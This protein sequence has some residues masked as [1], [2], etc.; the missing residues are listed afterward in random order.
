MSDY[1]SDGSLSEEGGEEVYSFS[2]DED[3]SDQLDSLSNVTSASSSSS[4]LQGSES[5]GLSDSD[6]QRNTFSEDEENSR[7]AASV[8]EIEN[9]FLQRRNQYQSFYQEGGINLTGVF[10]LNLEH[11]YETRKNERV[12]VK[13][14]RRHRYE[15]GNLVDALMNEIRRR[16]IYSFPQTLLLIHVQLM[17]RAFWLGNNSERDLKKLKT[18]MFGFYPFRVNRYQSALVFDTEIMK[19]EVE[20]LDTLLRLIERNQGAATHLFVPSVTAYLINN[21]VLNTDTLLG[22]PQQPAYSMTIDEANARREVAQIR[23]SKD[24]YGS[25]L[26][27]EIINRE[28]TTSYLPKRQT[29]RGIFSTPK[30]GFLAKEFPTYASY[31]YHQGMIIDESLPLHGYYPSFLME[32]DYA[33]STRAPFVHNVMRSFTQR[34]KEQA[35]HFNLSPLSISG[36]ISL[37]KA[38]YHACWIFNNF[39]VGINYISNEDSDICYEAQIETGFVFETLYGPNSN[40]LNNPDEYPQLR[41]NP[42]VGFSSFVPTKDFSSKD[43][44]SYQEA[45]RKRIFAWLIVFKMVL[46]HGFKTPMLLAL[47][48][49]IFQ[50]AH[51]IYCLIENE[52]SESKELNYE[53]TR[54]SE[55]VFVR[56]FA[57]PSETDSHVR[58]MTNRGSSTTDIPF[59]TPQFLHIG[60]YTVIKLVDFFLEHQKFFLEDSNIH[61]VFSG[62]FATHVTDSIW[63]V[64]DNMRTRSSILHALNNSEI[65]SSTIDTDWG[66]VSETG[67][68]RTTIDAAI[69]DAYPTVMFGSRSLNLNELGNACRRVFLSTIP[70]NLVDSEIE[71]GKNNNYSERNIGRFLNSKNPEVR[72][73]AEILLGMRDLNETKNGTGDIVSYLNR[74]ATVKW[75]AADPSVSLTEKHRAVTNSLTNL[76]PFRT[77]EAK[78]SKSGILVDYYPVTV[79]QTLTRP[80]ARNANDKVLKRIAEERERVRG[81]LEGGIRH[82]SKKIKQKRIPFTVDEEEEL[83]NDVLLVTWFVQS[84]FFHSAPYRKK[85]VI[86]NKGKRFDIFKLRSYNQH[87]QPVTLFVDRK[88]HSFNNE[89]WTT[90]IQTTLNV[91]HHPV[92]NIAVPLIGNYTFNSLVLTR[93]LDKK[94]GDVVPLPVSKGDLFSR[95]GEL[96]AFLL[97]RVAKISILFPSFECGVNYLK[98]VGFKFMMDPRRHLFTAT[99]GNKTPGVSG[100]SIFHLFEGYPITIDETSKNSGGGSLLTEENYLAWSLLRQFIDMISTTLR[101]RCNTNDYTFT[102]LEMSPWFSTWVSENTRLAINSQIIAHLSKSA[103]PLDV[104]TSHFYQL[105]IKDVIQ[106]MYQGVFKDFIDATISLKIKAAVDSSRERDYAFLKEHFNQFTRSTSITRPRVRYEMPPITSDMMINFWKFFES[107]PPGATN[108]LP[109][110]FIN[111]SVVDTFAAHE[112]LSLQKKAKNLLTPVQV[113]RLVALF[114]EPEMK[115]KGNKERLIIDPENAKTFKSTSDTTASIPENPGAGEFYAQITGYV[116]RGID[117]LSTIEYNSRSPSLNHYATSRRSRTREA[118]LDD[119]SKINRIPLY[120]TNLRFIYDTNARFIKHESEQQDDDM[121][122]RQRLWSPVFLSKEH[123]VV[124]LRYDSERKEWHLTAKIYL[125]EN[126]VIGFIFG[127][128]SPVEI[129]TESVDV[130]DPP[131]TGTPESVPRAN[132][133]SDYVSGVC[134]NVFDRETLYPTDK[135]GWFEYTHTRT[136]KPVPYGNSKFDTRMFTENVNSSIHVHSETETRNIVQEVR[137]ETVKTLVSPLAYREAR[138]ICGYEINGS[139]FSNNIRYVRYTT[140]PEL[141]NAIFKRIDRRKIAMF[142]RNPDLGYWCLVATKY[143]PQGA[144]I[145]ALIPG[146]NE[147]NGNQVNWRKFLISGLPSLKLPVDVFGNTWDYPIKPVPIYAPITAEDNRSPSSNA[148]NTSLPVFTVRQIA[149]GNVLK[150]QEALNAPSTSSTQQ[151]PVMNHPEYRDPLLHYLDAH[152]HE[153]SNDYSNFLVEVANFDELYT[154]TRE[155]PGNLVTRPS[156]VPSNF[157]IKRMIDLSSVSEPPQEQ[158]Y[159]DYDVFEEEKST[160]DDSDEKEEEKKE[161]EEG[162]PEVRDDEEQRKPSEEQTSLVDD[163]TPSESEDLVIPGEEFILEIESVADFTEVSLPSSSSSSSSSMDPEQNFSRL[164]LE[165]QEYLSSSTVESTNGS[166]FSE[167]FNHRTEDYLRNYWV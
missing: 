158:S 32:G 151:I 61:F 144:E 23:L 81:Q 29:H 42:Y 128:V 3:N 95:K 40:F 53:R 16:L 165:D 146:S 145:I 132:N 57:N 7:G 15:G 39:G 41:D 155:Y 79:T 126:N 72:R 114:R 46:R 6:N 63:S 117:E 64:Y 36:K 156:I 119:T 8:K 118:L 71:H 107:Q 135:F 86:L 88:G 163:Q 18:T 1:S 31:P 154:R 87:L 77:K 100:V 55:L 133:F 67:I 167:R 94:I 138:V 43:F 115:L 125:L 91:A 60:Y 68:R 49:D 19:G 159:P 28:I 130:F 20:Y 70:S 89:W 139:R 21:V 104:S 142:G 112:Y 113:F 147:K 141:A 47:F 127:E 152:N 65:F 52:N 108:T 123:N 13:T 102:T 121:S 4:Y 136:I 22:F 34:F 73:A 110:T 105:A 12:T 137:E 116:N 96:Q 83:I 124:N 109:R 69:M 30:E 140:Q 134:E 129:F 2:E 62:C 45:N 25:G 84:P 44:V 37:H 93:K 48:K 162:E 76:F 51:Y 148:Y 9:A 33:L 150:L 90:A 82:I 166:S 157:P 106:R 85:V 98:E 161:E 74:L 143:I 101:F 131:E 103:F 120:N 56:L 58:Y 153:I 75:Y 35:T 149:L 66:N 92:L 80:I 122:G 78:E 26:F 14:V 27:R 97:E 111:W 38:I 10:L 11:F 59:T 50:Y 54:L 99:S 5:E 160:P 24:L 17:D 164:L